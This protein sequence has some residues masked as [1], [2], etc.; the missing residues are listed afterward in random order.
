VALLGH[1]RA[2]R[3]ARELDDLERADDAARVA[4]LDAC[5]GDGVAAYELG[6]ERCGPFLGGL[7][8]EGGAHARVGPG[9][10]DVVEERTHVEPRTADEDGASASARDVR[11]ARAGRGLVL[12][13]GRVLLD[14]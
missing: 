10:A 14:V 8:L 4:R 9:E 13:D 11:K 2:E 5:R 12:R 1:R 3:F 7:L 6:E